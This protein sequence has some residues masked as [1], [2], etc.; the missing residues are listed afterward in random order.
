MKLKVLQFDFIYNQ[1]FNDAVRLP[2]LDGIIPPYQSPAAFHF[3]WQGK[4]RYCSLMD[5]RA[6]QANL[7]SALICLDM[8]KGN[9]K[10]NL[11]KDIFKTAS[12]KKH[13]CVNP[14]DPSVVLDLSEPDIGLKEVQRQWKG[15][16]SSSVAQQPSGA[17]WEC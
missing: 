6:A 12:K 7:S 17:G 13:C 4:V 16:A 15:G 9:E 10:L 11:Y 8:G 2:P 1:T 14:I 3:C 5:Y